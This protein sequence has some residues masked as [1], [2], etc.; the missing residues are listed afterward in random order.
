MST[1]YYAKKIPTES[2]KLDIIKS[3]AT[4]NLELA[5]KDLSEL[6]KL[7]HVGKRSSGWRFLF[8]HNNWDYYD[9]IPELKEW[10]K[11]YLLY[12]E[13]G[14]QVDQ[15]EFWEEI[16]SRQ[17]SQKSALTHSGNPS[18]YIIKDEYEFSSSSDFS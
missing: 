11:N 9:N 15:L 12:T 18:W 5:N 8:N 6:V 17:V 7:I 2:V 1:N 14:E 13:Y 10:L 16:E 3:I 4:D